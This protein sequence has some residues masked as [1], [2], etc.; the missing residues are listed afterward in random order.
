[1]ENDLSSSWGSALCFEVE[2]HFVAQA[3]LKLIIFLPPAPR[4]GWQ[5]CGYAPSRLL[6]LKQV[7]CALGAHWSQSQFRVVPARSSLPWS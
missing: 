2:F 5:I 7:A 3:S 6:C 1:M 4:L